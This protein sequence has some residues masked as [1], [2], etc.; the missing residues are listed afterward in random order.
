MNDSGGGRFGAASK[1]AVG[2]LGFPTNLVLV[3]LV[4]D[5][6]LFRRYASDDRGAGQ[7]ARRHRVRLGLERPVASQRGDSLLPGLLQAVPYLANQTAHL[8]LIIL[9]LL[10]KFHRDVF[11]VPVRRRRLCGHVRRLGTARGLRP[12]LEKSVNVVLVPFVP[13]V[14]GRYVRYIRY[15]RPS[16]R[17]GSPFFAAPLGVTDGDVVQVEA[18][19]QRAD[20]LA[21]VSQRRGGRGGAVEPAPRVRRG[22]PD[23]AGNVRLGWRRRSSRRP[24]RRSRGTSAHRRAR[25]PR[26]GGPDAPAGGGWSRP[27]RRPGRRRRRRS[28]RGRRRR[29]AT[30]RPPRS[31]PPSRAPPRAGV[32]LE[33]E[34]RQRVQ[35]TQRLHHAGD[36]PGQLALAEVEYLKLG[37]LGGKVV[38]QRPQRVLSA[39]EFR[40]FLHPRHGV[41]VVQGVALEVQHVQPFQRLQVPQR[42]RRQGVVRYVELL[43][44]GAL[45]D[46][47]YFR[48]RVAADVELL[49]RVK[50]REPLQLLEPASGYVQ[51]RQRRAS[52][53]QLAV[54]ERVA[55]GV[56]DGEP[57]EMF[58]AVQGRD[59]V[60]LTLERL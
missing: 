39:V 38:G 14:S 1:R 43:Q 28:P 16:P 7:P 17:A 27:R 55:A 10:D 11:V 34:L 58:D 56:E 33:P 30:V 26:P 35:S 31:M 20:H 22:G 42:G 32:E 48:Q 9:H 54:P 13:V 57:S 18:P 3:D 52:S 59:G 44:L 60:V 50:R 12:P 51:P 19:R 8:G 25:R 47:G 37:A 46:G 53:D 36:V 40:E 2:S 6:H 15:V 5:A 21:T 45:G 24:R 49:E 23:V 41:Q 4:E 29:R